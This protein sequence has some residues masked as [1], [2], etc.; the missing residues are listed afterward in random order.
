MLNKCLGAFLLG[1]IMT[2]YTYASRQVECWVIINKA[3]A[4]SKENV[5]VN[6]LDYSTKE[7]IQTLNLPGSTKNK[8]SINSD[9][10][11]FDCNQHTLIQM[12]A[13][14]TPR[15]WSTD[16][17]KTYLSKNTYNLYQQLINA[18]LAKINKLEITLKFPDDFIGVPEMVN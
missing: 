7:V 1:L 17:G 12:Q 9:S 18:R 10:Q 8:S 6:V 4:W 13:S 2:S 14:Y 3:P 11:T 15:I 16:V 5:V